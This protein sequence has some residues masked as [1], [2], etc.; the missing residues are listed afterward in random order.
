MYLLF[1]WVSDA[2]YAA[3]Y[4]LDRDHK[5]YPHVHKTTAAWNSFYFWNQRRFL[6]YSQSALH[7]PQ[8]LTS[9]VGK[10]AFSYTSY[11]KTV[12][13]P[14]CLHSHCSAFSLKHDGQTMW[15][16]SFMI[17]SLLALSATQSCIQDFWKKWSLAKLYRPPINIFCFSASTVMF[18]KGP[19]WH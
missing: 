9:P 6:L 7:P 19:P 5:G 3:C 16:T 18:S 1:F 11:L 13:P 10:K 15:P 12:R 14:H 8:M 17:S 4:K 2:S